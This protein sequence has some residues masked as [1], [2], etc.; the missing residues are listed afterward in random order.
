[1]AHTKSRFGKLN[2]FCF[3]TFKYHFVP[4][5]LRRGGNRHIVASVEEPRRFRGT[6]A[7]RTQ[8]I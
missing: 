1:M 5:I 2:V 7:Y 4:Y 8:V 3:E 6:E